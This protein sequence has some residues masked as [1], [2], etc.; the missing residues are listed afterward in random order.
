MLRLNSPPSSTRLS[1]MKKYLSCLL[2]ALMIALCLPAGA[3][4]ADASTHITA[5]LSGNGQY[6]EIKGTLSDSDLDAVGGEKLSLYRVAPGETPSAGSADVT[7]ITPRSGISIQAPVKDTGAL[8]YV[9]GY[10]KENGELVTVGNTAY[11]VNPDVFS[12]Y[13]YEQPE[14]KSKKGLDITMPADA[15]LLGV[16]HTVVKVLLN[17]FIKEGPDDA[18][19]YKYGGATYYFDKNRCAVLDYC[20]K[21]YSDAGM[22][23]YIQLLLGPREDGQPEFLYCPGADGNADYYAVN[24]SSAEARGSLFAFVRFLCEKY[25]SGKNGFCGNFI[26]G[27]EINSN[28]YKNNAGPASLS[29]YTDAY[30]AALRTVDFAARSVYSGARVFVSVAN[31]FNKPSYDNNADPTLDYSVMDLLSHLSKH[32]S[33]GG[34]IP[35]CLSV[36]PYNIDRSRA[37]FRGAEGSEYSYESRYVT[38]DNINIITSLLSQP[39]YLY[40]GE[41]RRVI[42]GEISYPCPGGSEEAQK[43]QAAAYAL[44]Y[45]KAACNDQIDAIIYA[46]QVDRADKADGAGLYTR[47]DGTNDTASSEKSIY[48]LF[49]YIDTEYSSVISEQYLSYYGLVSWGEAVSGYSP[50]S[51]ARRVV[52]SGTAMTEAPSGRNEL[53]ALTGFDGNDLMFYPSENAKLITTKPDP[54][55][56]ELYGRENSLYAELYTVSDREYRGVSANR[57]FTFGKATHA[58]A[59]LRVDGA[60]GIADVMLRLTG[61]DGE[62]RPV[63]YEGTAAVTVGQYYRLYFDLGEFSGVCTGDVSRMSVWVKPHNGADNGEY[64]LLLNGVSVIGDGKGKSGSVVKTVIIVII[65]IV[66]I[67]AAAYGIMYLRALINYK[68]K[69]KRIEEKR[70]RKSGSI[71]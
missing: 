5:Q 9:L 46:D 34:D 8:G 70:R 12:Q 60:A 15:Q 14:V 2:A 43:A 69:K 11:V 42:I 6:V 52:I 64:T 4:A 18:A 61:A 59:D 26:L 56:K 47:V 54:G 63:V 16:S 24:V 65:V 58:V 23:V 33:D 39:S 67:A 66:L 25:T 55:A 68:K 49:K 71:Q 21:T 22:R 53:T 13:K 19:A 36:D 51:N 40:G 32:I 20:V 28:R 48:R 44:A 38:M 50:S 7:G 29:S 1:K 45:Y 62:G 31:N 17:E 10:E 3:A 35:W 57:Q 27:S 37:D 30:A 41:R